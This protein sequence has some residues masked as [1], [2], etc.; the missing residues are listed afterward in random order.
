MVL[1]LLWWCFVVFVHGGSVVVVIYVNI[2][3]VYGAFISVVG[4]RQFF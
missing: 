2:F 3:V 4:V 1:L